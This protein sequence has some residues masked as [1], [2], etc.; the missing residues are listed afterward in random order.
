MALSVDNPTRRRRHPNDYR[1][2]SREVKQT[3]MAVL[4]QFE[5]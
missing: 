1:L 4:S 2:S 3:G 5:P